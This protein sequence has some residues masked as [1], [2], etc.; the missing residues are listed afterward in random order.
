MTNYADTNNAL[1]TQIENRFFRLKPEIAV[2][3]GGDISRKVYTSKQAAILQNGEIGLT[4]FLCDSIKIKTVDGDPAFELECKEL[5][6]KYTTG[7]VLAYI[8]TERLMWG[9]KAHQPLDSNKIKNEYDAFVQN[10]IM[11]EGKVQLTK[12]EQAFDFYKSHY[13]QLLAKPFDMD[14]LEPTNPFEPDSKFQEIGRTS[15]EIRDQ[16][17]LKTIDSLLDKKNK[18]FIV[19]GGWH[20]LTCQPGLEE[21]IRRKRK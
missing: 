12:P 20:L 8:V 4:K 5:L 9:L 18:I 2:N 11:H 7:E 21:L 13:Q 3:E 15:K 19:F 16:Y 1:F 14:E 17:L 10:Y 6:E